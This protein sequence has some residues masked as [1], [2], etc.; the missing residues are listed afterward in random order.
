[1]HPKS[2]RADQPAGDH[3]VDLRVLDMPVEAQD[4]AGGGQLVAPVTAGVAAIE[5][6]NISRRAKQ[7]PGLRASWPGGVGVLDGADANH[8]TDEE[9]SGHVPGPNRPGA[10]SVRIAGAAIPEY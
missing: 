6:A 7:G 2:P 5:R 8:T 1:M 3:A 4:V 10:G 9:G